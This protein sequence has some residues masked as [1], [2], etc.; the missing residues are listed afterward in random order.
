L[1]QGALGK[2][3]DSAAHRQALDTIALQQRKSE[4]AKAKFVESN[5]RLVVSIA[6]RYENRGLGPSDLIQEG[7]IGLMRAIEKFDYRRGYKFSTYATWWIRQS[8]NRALSDQSRTIRYPVHMVEAVQRLQRAQRELGHK[9]GRDASTEELAEQSGMSLSK[10]RNLLEAVPEP[11]SLDIPMGE[12]ARDNLVDFIADKSTASPWDELTRARKEVHAH[13]LFDLLTPRE[14]EVIR[15]RFGLHGSPGMTLEAV[16][17]RM[18][19]TRERIRQIE[20]R[21]LRKLRLPF[22]FRGLKAYFEE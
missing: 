6:K 9:L 17:Q 18:S 20:A 2:G 7:N 3:K 13:Q 22:Q 14:Q 8:L 11:I 15:L 10:V 1:R 19:L 21:A 4:R 16:G 5:L 12:S